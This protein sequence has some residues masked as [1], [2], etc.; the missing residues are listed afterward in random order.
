MSRID[1]QEDYSFISR[2]IQFVVKWQEK[3]FGEKLEDKFSF[4]AVLYAI[5]VNSSLPVTHLM[6]Q[7]YQ[8]VGSGGEVQEKSPQ[9]W[10]WVL[11]MLQ[12]EIPSGS[13]WWFR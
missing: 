12:V 9:F 4:Q 1:G 2:R 13:L 10:D 6:L 8:S 11:A 7:C 3:A 5:V